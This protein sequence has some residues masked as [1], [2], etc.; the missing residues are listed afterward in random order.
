MTGEQEPNGWELL[1]AIRGIEANLTSFAA[2]YVP[3]AVYQTLVD[4]VRKTEEDVVTERKDREA[5]VAAIQ[6]AQD[7]QRK[8]RAQTW[9]AMGLIAVTAVV[10]IFVS[11]FRQGVG[12]P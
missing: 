7:E 2:N 8:S 6:K 1:R 9:T 10:G 11:F 12:L 5:A 3:V 4:R